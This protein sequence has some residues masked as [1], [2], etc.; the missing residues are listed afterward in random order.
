MCLSIPLPCQKVAVRPTATSSA[1]YWGRWCVAHEEAHRA[2]NLAVSRLGLLW[3][4]PT[5]PTVH[6]YV[7]LCHNKLPTA[8]GEGWASLATDLDGA[9]RWRGLQRMVRVVECGASK[10]LRCKLVEELRE[11]ICP[12]LE[13]EQLERVPFSV[14]LQVSPFLA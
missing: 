6:P 4:G 13:D 11:V 8:R 9:R 5:P 1:L 2:I 3:L 10:C 14:L 7:E 12:L